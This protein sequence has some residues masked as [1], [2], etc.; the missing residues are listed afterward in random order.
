[1]HRNSKRNWI[2]KIIHI[3]MIDSA[4]D[5]DKYPLTIVNSD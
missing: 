3:D 5:I 1:M 4:G 2:G